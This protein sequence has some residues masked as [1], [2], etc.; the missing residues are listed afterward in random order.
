[1]VYTP[2]GS[3]DHDDDDVEA[4]VAAK[5]T[6]EMVPTAASPDQAHKGRPY[7]SPNEGLTVLV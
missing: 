2:L 6:E 7:G 5:K 4:N 3:Q 1:M